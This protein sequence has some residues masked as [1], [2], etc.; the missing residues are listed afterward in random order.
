MLLLKKLKLLGVDMQTGYYSGAGGM[1][2]EFNRLDML[3]TNL[4]NVNTTAYKQDNIIV[5]DFLR[6]FKNSRDQLPNE[7][8][9]K[10][11]AKFY[12]RTISRVPHIVEQYTDFKVGNLEKT[13]NRFDFALSK[14]NL[15]FLVKTPQGLRLTRD[16]S[17]TLD[18]EGR[19]VT[20]QGY[21][22]LPSD[23]F[24][25]NQPIRF[26]QTDEIITVDKDGNFYTNLPGRL[27]MVSST[28]FFIFHPENT[29][30]LKKVGDNL[31]IYEDEAEYKSIQN[32]KAVRQGFLEK[33]NVNPVLMMT[34]LIEANRM[35]DMYKKVM[36]TQMDDM[37][38]EAI[39]KLSK[40]A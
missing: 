16:G 38:Q 30:K 25:T 21:E 36:E 29:Q 4:A 34:G 31:Y 18:D 20:K 33:S 5:G 6:I 15:F 27:N 39:T 35:V 37:N 32:S 9:T 2:V 23:Y 7:N 12:N 10:E 26:N 22:V 19:L 17:F 28:S 1:V 14:E 13:D 24:D 3:A 8:N 40:R 11:A